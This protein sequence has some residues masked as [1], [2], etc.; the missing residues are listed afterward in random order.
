V[1]R[2]TDGLTELPEGSNNVFY[3]THPSLVIYVPSSVVN[4]YKGMTSWSSWAGKIQ[5]SY[6]IGDTGPAGGWIF[7]V[8]TD[9]N[10][11]WTYLECAPA[12]INISGTVKFEWGGFKTTIGAEG[13]AIGS[14]QANTNVIISALGTGTYAA[15]LCDDY[16][17]G[18]YTDWF[19]PSKDELNQIYLNKSLANPP[20][21]LVDWYWSSSESSDNKN[22]W[23]QRFEESAT[24]TNEY[25]K[26]DTYNVRAIR[27]F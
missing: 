9:D 15:K 3:N 13:T 5:A 8:D 6:Q 1:L 18:G 25:H 24:Y 22:A 20:G 19:L 12:D 26:T 16:E 10:F 11:P 17:Y 14:G 4:E 27:S 7:Y 2:E 21:G 23:L